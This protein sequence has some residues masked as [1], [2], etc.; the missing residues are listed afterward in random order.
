MKPF[1]A[2]F[3]YH[4]L[5]AIAATNYKSLVKHNS[6]ITIIPIVH[7]WKHDRMLDG[8]VDTARLDVPQ[9]PIT[10]AWRQVDVPMIRWFLKGRTEDFER[11]CLIE[12]DCL[13]RQSLV[14]FFEPYKK[15][16]IV[17]NWI[18]DDNLD[19][20]FWKELP[21]EL[22][23]FKAGISPFVCTCFSHKAME[24]MSS[25]T[26]PLIKN[27]YCELKAGVIAKKYSLTRASYK[28]QTIHYQTL[29]LDLLSDKG[30]FHPVKQML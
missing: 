13:V 24:V 10:D 15:S 29:R 19:W 20:P 6:D 4:K 1:V 25:E 3:L 26:N 21:D 18:M 30:I 23:P 2:F 22:L 12:Y 16:D 28:T 14:E 7:S 11:Y 8:T 5:D 9:F 17:A 27:L